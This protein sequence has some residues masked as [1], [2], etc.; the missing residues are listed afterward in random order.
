LGHVVADAEAGQSG[1]A[2]IVPS[3]SPSVYRFRGG[4]VNLLPELLVDILDGLPIQGHQLIE[5]GGEPRSLRN[6][7]ELILNY[8]RAQ[9][10]LSSGVVEG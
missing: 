1:V 3:W 6:H 10:P 4:R 8:F 7:R 9:K 2:E 5:T